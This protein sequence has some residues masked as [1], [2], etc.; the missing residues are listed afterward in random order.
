[1][2]FF[3]QAQT[4]PLL[5]NAPP[6]PGG[7]DSLIRLYERVMETLGSKFNT[8]SFVGVLKEINQAKTSVSP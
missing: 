5:P 1:M 6:L 4:M 3:I 8:A 2:S 7:Q